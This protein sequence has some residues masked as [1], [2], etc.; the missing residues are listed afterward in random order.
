[1]YNAF[2]QV[3]NKEK[4]NTQMKDKLIKAKRDLML[5]IGFLKGQ[6]NTNESDVD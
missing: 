2:I 4:Q 5:D 3:I 6:H 1:M